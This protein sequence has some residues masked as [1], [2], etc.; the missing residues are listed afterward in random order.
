MTKVPRPLSAVFLALVAPV[1]STGASVAADT[2]VIK[3]TSSITWTYNGKS[4]K[5]D[6]TPLVVDD[7]K[8]GD[9][10]DVQVSP[11][12]PHG[13]ITIKQVANLLPADNETRD[14]VVACGEQASSK[15][16]AVL[17]EIECGQT[18]KFGVKFTGSLKLEVLKT[19]QSDTNF[20][21]VVHHFGMTGVLKL[22][23]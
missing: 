13:L 20:W 14:L 19:F 22:K 7:L 11:G 1:I 18:S 17:A 6:G 16:T 15:P 9:I 2:H 5:T 23:Q 10:I 4:S 8:V 12:I 3:A 21:C